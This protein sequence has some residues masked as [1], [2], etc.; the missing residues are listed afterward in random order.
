MVFVCERGLGSMLIATDVKNDRVEH[1]LPLMTVEGPKMGFSPY[2]THIN[3]FSNVPSD[4]T[5]NEIFYM[6]WED[7]VYDEI[8]SAKRLNE[9]FVVAGIRKDLLL[10]F[11]AYQDGNLLKDGFLTQKGRVIGSQNGGIAKIISEELN[12]VDIAYEQIRIE[13][14]KP[15]EF[16]LLMRLL[17]R[18]YPSYSRGYN[19]F[20]LPEGFDEDDVLFI[21]S[22]NINS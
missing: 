1:G 9:S 12:G 7:L 8:E 13:R 11:Q 21:S 15:N 17:E 3:L 18:R 19:M 5:L 22:T 14:N 20:L 4:E 16:L 10:Y 6:R 2:R